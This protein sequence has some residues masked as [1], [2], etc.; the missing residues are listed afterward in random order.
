VVVI[1]DSRSEFP[2]AAEVAKDLRAI[3][4]DAVVET[5]WNGRGLVKGLS[6]AGKL[7]G[8]GG[9]FAFRPSGVRAVLLGSRER[10]TGAV[11]IKDLA[12]GAQQT[13]P[14]NA[15]SEVLGAARDR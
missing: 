1:P 15:L 2:Y 14:R 10:E 8:E 12:T 7:A 9:G 6:R 11:T 13:F 4:P 3:L 5:D